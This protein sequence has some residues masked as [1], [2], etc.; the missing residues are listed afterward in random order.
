MMSV[1]IL[2]LIGCYFIG[3]LDFAYIV[4]KKVK[5]DDIRNYGSGNAGTTNVLRT[6]GLKY[7]GIVLLL[8]ALKGTLCI[9]IAKYLSL[10]FGL[11]PM[12]VAGA[13]IAVL[14]GHNWP[15]LLKFRGGKGT[16]TS[17]GLF[18]LYDWRIALICIAIALVILAIFKMVSLASI[19][20]MT[21]LPFVTLLFFGVSNL[22]AL[23]LTIFMALS[24]DIQHRSN[25]KRIISGT[26]SKIGQHIEMKK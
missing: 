11:N 22:P 6:L 13:G 20:G 19:T 14:C 21:I 26:E 9:G 23:V 5:N 8:D 10:K 25:I 7:A 3:N 16:A 1:G 2:L 17:I 24:T 4:V 15:I 18:L 12:W